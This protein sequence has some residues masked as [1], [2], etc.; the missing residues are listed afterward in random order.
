[1]LDADDRLVVRASLVS[2]RRNFNGEVWSVFRPGGRGV[3]PAE[4]IQ[5]NQQHVR[6]APSYELGP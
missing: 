5:L 2:F 6:D 3:E 4:G 1:M